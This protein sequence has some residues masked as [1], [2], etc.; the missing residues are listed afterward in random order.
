MPERQTGFILPM[1]QIGV[2]F[3][4][5]VKTGMWKRPER[6]TT[7]KKVVYDPIGK[8][9]YLDWN[10]ETPEDDPQG[11]MFELRTLEYFV[12]HAWKAGILA[13]SNLD[14]PRSAKMVCVRYAPAA[15]WFVIVMEHTSF[16]PDE[17]A[18]L[19]QLGV[20]DAQAHRNN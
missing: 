2:L 3:D 19:V 15:N 13:F 6:A 12:E 14:V 18:P 8:L 5:L 4:D 9:A 16:I 17:R 10:G 20:P 7:V 11:Q 1:D